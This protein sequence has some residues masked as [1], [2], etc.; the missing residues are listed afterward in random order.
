M[1]NTAALSA[2]RAQ[3]A[4]QTR[5]IIAQMTG[6]AIRQ[7]GHISSFHG[8]GSAG[9]IPYFS[10][11]NRSLGSAAAGGTIL[12]GIGL[13]AILGGPVGAVV[14]GGIGGVVAPVIK[15]LVEIPSKLKEFAEGVV[16]A[17]RGLR[18]FNGGISASYARLDFG[19]LRRAFGR[20]QQ[21]AGSASQL[22]DSMNSFRDTIEPAVSRG[23]T[24]LNLIANK[25]T[26]TVTAI[27]KAAAEVPWLRKIGAKLDAIEKE[28]RKKEADKAIPAI[29]A[30]N[31]WAKQVP[32]RRGIPPKP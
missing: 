19:D 15:G 12:A 21:T 2:L 4:A 24:V 26:V 28:L 16:E 3:E 1:S 27:T 18:Q 29:Q 25:L 31:N 7:M 32:Q 17:N 8:E 10:Q 22:N 23:I 20:A 9:P 14:G 6:D 5:Q 11:G 30:L 13:G